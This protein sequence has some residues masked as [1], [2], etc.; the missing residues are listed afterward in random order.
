MGRLPKKQGWRYSTKEGAGWG[1]GG[2]IVPKKGGA[3]RYGVEREP[4]KGNGCI[5]F[6]IK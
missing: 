5:G 6:N 4:K 2:G 1:R 3:V